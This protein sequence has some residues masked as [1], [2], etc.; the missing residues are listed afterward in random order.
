MSLTAVRAHLAQ[1]GRDE[2]IVVFQT[3]SATVELAAAALE[4]EPARIAKTLSV[5]SGDGTS[6]VLIVV[7]GDAR[8]A[9]GAFKRRFGYKPRMLRADD[10]EALTGHT[11][12]GVCPFGNPD[13]TQVWLDESLRR[14]DLVWPAAGDPSSA[15]GVSL[16]ELEWF[17]GAQGWVD[18]AGGWR[19]DDTD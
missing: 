12:G 14:F 15:V 9:G 4:V 18:V 3:S 5:Y 10:V 17:S 19:E 1:F 13:G 16:D 2:T 6:A 7:A 11:I 8:L